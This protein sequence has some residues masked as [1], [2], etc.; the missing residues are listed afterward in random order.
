M[1]QKDTKTDRR[2]FLKVASAATTLSWAGTSTAVGATKK[3]TLALD[4]GPKAVTAP[5]AWRWPLYGDE[6]EKAM[7]ALTQNPSYAP[8]ARLEEEWKT[9]TG[10]PYSRAHCNGTGA[11]TGMFFALTA[12]LPPGS[13]IMVPSYTFFA[14][15]VPMRLFGFVPVFVDIDPQ[16]LNF[17]LEDAKRKLTKNTRAV[18]PVH[19]IGLPCPMDAI[20][21]WA[22]EKGLIV[23]EDACH[24]QGAKLNGKRMGTWGRM[25]AY[26]FQL[27][28]ALPGFEGG[29]ANYQNRDDYD[30][31][32][33]FGFYRKCAGKYAAYDGTGLGVKLRIHPMAAELVRT[34]L[35]GLDKRNADG[36][37]RT[38]AL[39]DRL[40]QLPG[41][42]EQT[43][44]HPGIERIYYAW[45]MLFLDEKEAGF[46]RAA[47]VKA[48]QAE[49]VKTSNFGYLLQHEGALYREAKW[50]H[51]APKI[52]TRDELPGTYQAN[53]WAL[54][55]PYFTED[56]PE[57]TEQYVRAF[58]K[59][60]ANRDNLV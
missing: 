60:W 1:N 3:E 44:D 55:L 19:W 5:P 13:E 12:E 20:C 2:T 57:L 29:I 51:H 7:V 22:K 4:G 17:D 21:D 6:E 52:P 58:E 48:L 49:G 43:Y 28:K 25:G 18:L 59:V 39:N 16:T 27:S 46:T 30:R 8:W 23:L 50:W 56:C 31:A 47:A 42:K 38:R 9:F 41:L 53:E 15:I 11:L 36:V 35:K 26:S 14:T 34:Q 33:A 32:S 10:S 37:K 24:T 54:P 45:N 40:C